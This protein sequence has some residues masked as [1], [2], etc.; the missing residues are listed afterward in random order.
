MCC[1]QSHSLS[2]L[3]PSSCNSSSKRV[4]TSS[5]FFSAGFVW[6]EHVFSEWLA[7]LNPTTE[8]ASNVVSPLPSPT[9]D[10]V[11]CTCYCISLLLVLVN[12]S[13]LQILF[14]INAICNS[15]NIYAILLR[16]IYAIFICT[17]NG[18]DVVDILSY[19]C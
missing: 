4:S 18:L 2:P 6:V 11:Y 7:V 13:R 1:L 12:Y 16:D 10:E 5:L 17:K 9:S 8:E 15:T 19:V 3:H 14:R